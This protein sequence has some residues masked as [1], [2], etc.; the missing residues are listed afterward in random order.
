MNEVP[1]MKKAILTVLIVSLPVWAQDR[2]PAAAEHPAPNHP[3]EQ[4]R[5][6]Q[7]GPPPAPAHPR[8]PE[9]H[10]APQG[11][12]PEAHRAPENRN[13]ADQHGHPNAPHVHDNGQWIG[14][15]SGRNDEHF[16][17]EHPWEHG[18]FTG[19]FG[20]KHVFALRGGSRDRF[21]F[22]GFYFS[23]AP[24]DFD[25]VGDWLWDSDSIVLYE[26]PDHPGWYLAY[27]TRLGTYAHVMYL[28][29]Q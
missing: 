29:P 22:D 24:Y 8:A 4:H 15:D 6:P 9:T 13:F 18:H 26:D 12:A 23:V 25:Y 11:H 1:M 16:R 28:G 5:I 3:A 10:S 7:Q 14:H 20:P 27:N 2:R 21:F 17:L 19:G